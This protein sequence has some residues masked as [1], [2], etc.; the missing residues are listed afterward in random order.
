MTQ[1]AEDG[2]ERES[3]RAGGVVR[4][5]RVANN[6][7]CTEFF[8]LLLRPSLPTHGGTFF[9]FSFRRLKSAPGTSRWCFFFRAWERG[10]PHAVF[11]PRAASPPQHTHNTQGRPVP[12][13]RSY[14]ATSH[15]R[16]CAQRR[17]ARCEK[18]PACTPVN[19]SVHHDNKAKTEKG[20][21]Y[22][23][24]NKQGGGGSSSMLFTHARARARRKKKTKSMAAAITSWTTPCSCP[25]GA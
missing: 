15:R 10:S 8:L 22:T 16:A 24:K 5:S 6:V 2:P 12:L 9:F 3:A 17:D 14:A 7:T 21:V 18:P 4:R 25:T 11:G 13:C 23:Q 1:H 19:S 20:Y